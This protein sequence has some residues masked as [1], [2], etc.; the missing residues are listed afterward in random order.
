M[1]INDLTCFLDL[2][3]GCLLFNHLLLHVYHSIGFQ[4]V[5][6]A[7]HQINF[8]LLKTAYVLLYTMRN[9]F[10]VSGVIGNMSGICWTHD[11]NFHLG[12]DLVFLT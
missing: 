9:Y 1:P 6:Q 2:I 5:K 12:T 11:I 10:M 4:E 7:W 3:I 8:S